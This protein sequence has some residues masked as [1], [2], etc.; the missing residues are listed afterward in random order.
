MTNK[1]KEARF[2]NNLSQ[3]M[4][5]VTTGISQTKISLIENSF[6]EPSEAEKKKLAKA[7]NKKV[8]ELFIDC[9]KQ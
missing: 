3:W 8:G 7:L 4:L 5:A 9:S 6:V 2:K 1:L